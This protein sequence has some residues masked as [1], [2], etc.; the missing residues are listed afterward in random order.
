MTIDN[1]SEK[2]AMVRMQQIFDLFTELSAD[3]S[4]HF[5]KVLKR[6][7]ELVEMDIGIISHIDKSRYEVQEVFC[8]G[9]DVI[10]K[11]QSFSLEDTYCSLTF[12]SN[13]IVDLNHIGA[14]E[15][16][17][18]PCYQNTE[19]EAYIGVPIV[20]SG[21]K[22]GTLNFSSPSPRKNHF[23]QFDRDFVLYLGQWLGQHI[24]R[25]EYEKKLSEKNKQLQELLDEREKLSSIL[26]HDLKAPLN[27]LSGLLD[28]SESMTDEHVISD[29]MKDSLN[30]AFGLI[31]DLQEIN[32]LE[33]GLTKFQPTV[34][35][36]VEIAEIIIGQFINASQQKNINLVLLSIE[37][38]IPVES[39]M[40]LLCRSL[41]NLVSNAIKFSN[42]DSTVELSVFQENDQLH[43]RVKDQGPGIS[44]EDQKKLFKRF[45][46]L[47][48]KPTAN[49]H[50]SGLG[51]YIV[52]ENCKIMKGDIAVES[53]VDHGT[54][55][56]LSI[57]LKV[58]DN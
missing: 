54:A 24:T 41:N 1:F 16:C 19:L 47:S 57:P 36:G 15:H 26:I 53:K 55:F 56:T 18:H 33:Q 34:L 20:V 48:A 10:E 32:Q 28:I 12:A 50:S 45:Q 27:N 39:D 6:A 7:T 3:Q 14:S 35:N 29:M 22:Y 51:L 46:R 21:K 38:L 44:K 49:E 17:S 52:K 5:D 2:R 23:N 13:N 58:Q 4:Y 8:T 25:L 9:E 43:Y 31:K 37:E 40:K 11:G 42:A 30:R